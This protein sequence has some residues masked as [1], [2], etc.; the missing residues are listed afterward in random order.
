M[1]EK[2][3]VQSNGIKRVAEITAAEYDKYSKW[4][5]KYT[6]KSRIILVPGGGFL[7]CLWPKEE[8][9][10][11]DIL[12]KFSRNRIIVF[13]QTVTFDL[14]SKD[15]RKFFEES[16]KIYEAHPNLTIFVREAK[17]CRFM[18]EYMPKVNCYMVPDIVTELKTDVTGSAARSGIL[19]C[20]RSDL[21]KALPESDVRLIMECVK[22]RFKGESVEFTDMATKGGRV[23]PPQER[24]EEVTK[25]LKQFAASR[26]V[27][28][29]RLHGM[30]FS[31][32]VGTPCI[33]FNN[34]NGKVRMVYEWVKELP[35]I[36]FVDKPEDFDSV[37][38]EM[39]IDRTYIYDYHLVDNQF[40]PLK[41]VLKEL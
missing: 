39:D 4:L 32:L 17:S 13:P 8:Y 18:Q 15:G 11:R 5:A 30:I 40:Q 7:G 24:D 36:R 38:K 28:T 41:D 21:E 20:M 3:F 16:K 25:K 31:A 23:I 19:F 27:V 10:V 33:A 37:L 6:P 2:Q 34:S 12:K 26:L 29:D 1:A 9:R 14:G 22:T 35:Y